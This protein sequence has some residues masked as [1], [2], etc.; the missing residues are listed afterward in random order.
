MTPLYWGL[1]VGNRPQP[2]Q[3]Q[4]P[5]AMG[6]AL[7]QG[8]LA[9]GLLGPTR[10]TG[11]GSLVSLHMESPEAR[12]RG[13]GSTRQETR[14]LSWEVFSTPC[15][16]VVSKR[17]FSLFAFNR[18]QAGLSQARR[19]GFSGPHHQPSDLSLSHCIDVR[20]GLPPQLASHPSLSSQM[21]MQSHPLPGLPCLARHCW[22]KVQRTGL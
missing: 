14:N 10:G 2:T 4:W 7:F 13:I 9:Q 22:K 18:Q 20:R 8:L 6:A 5:D 15:P 16:F 11:S 19:P 1:G 12:H 17:R 21:P 3:M